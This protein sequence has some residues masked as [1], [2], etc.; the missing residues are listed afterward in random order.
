MEVETFEMKLKPEQD[1]KNSTFIKNAPI[2]LFSNSSLTPQNLS[3]VTWNE[4]YRQNGDD[5]LQSVFKVE[6]RNDF[7]VVN[8]EERGMK[9]TSII[10]RQQ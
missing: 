6:E 1:V 5:D 9:S 7:I 4:L 2:F 3:K 8:G 10:S